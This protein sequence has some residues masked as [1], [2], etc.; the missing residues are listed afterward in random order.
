MWGTAYALNAC[1]GLD[2]CSTG[3]LWVTW[4]SVQLVS[5]KSLSIGRTFADRGLQI[6]I[7]SFLNIT[8]INNLHEKSKSAQQTVLVFSFCCSWIS[9]TLIICFD[10]IVIVYVT[11]TLIAQKRSRTRRWWMKI[12][13]TSW[14]GSSG[15]KTRGWRRACPGISLSPQP[16]EWAPKVQDSCC[17]RWS[18]VVV[19]GLTF[20]SSFIEF[21]RR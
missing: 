8:R 11:D 1:L 17:E 14:S 19:H 7:T 20:Y 13:W 21:Y 16:R 18:C 2:C 12:R 4:S 5:W 3:L 15:K 6:Q 10:I 9:M